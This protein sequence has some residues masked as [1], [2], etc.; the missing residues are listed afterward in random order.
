MYLGGKL[1]I[2]RRVSVFYLAAAHAQ[3]VIPDW[4]QLLL[5]S[6]VLTAVGAVVT[7]DLFGFVSKYR[8]PQ[9]PGTIELQEKYGMPDVAKVVGVAFL[10]VGISVLIL[11]VVFGLVVLAR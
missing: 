9:S 3:S 4:L 11:F 7:F 2:H 1:G 8:V 10:C 6:L 5:I